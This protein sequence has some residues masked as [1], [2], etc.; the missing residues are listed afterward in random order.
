[1]FYFNHFGMAS[2]R[3]LSRFWAVQRF[4][5]LVIALLLGVILVP[6]LPKAAVFSFWMAQLSDWNL[7]KC[8]FLLLSDKTCG[9][10]VVTGDQEL[11]RV[12]IIFH[13]LLLLLWLVTL[14]VDLVFLLTGGLRQ[15]FVSFAAAHARNGWLWVDI[16][17]FILLRVLLALCL[18]L[19]HTQVILHKVIKL[20]RIVVVFEEVLL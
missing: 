13:P 14:V 6:G 1:M 2:V 3:N 10:F 4:F 8:S 5:A 18:L 15:V 19:N 16:T 9:L 17:L 12:S 20:A 11:E 7:T